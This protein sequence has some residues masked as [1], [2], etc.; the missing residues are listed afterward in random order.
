MHAYRRIQ[1]I[2]SIAKQYIIQSL[3]RDYKYYYIIIRGKYDAFSLYKY[4]TGC[5]MKQLSENKAY[6]NYYQFI[7]STKYRKLLFY[8]DE[9]REGLKRIINETFNANKEIELIESTVAYNHIHVLVKTELEPTKVGRLLFGR[10]SRVMRKEFPI[11][12]EQV[13]KGLWGGNSWEPIVDK[14]H[15]DNCISYIRRHQPD[16]TKTEN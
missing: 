1:L 5:R 16:N 9:I 3:E 2:H 8:N 4:H 6:E 15:L 11:L 14:K 13:S 10:T 12:V 7:G